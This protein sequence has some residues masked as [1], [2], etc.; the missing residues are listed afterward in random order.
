MALLGYQAWKADKVESGECTQTIRARRKN[1]VKVGETLYHYRGL[2]T[3]AAR[4]I[5]VSVC[6]ETFSLSLQVSKDG[7]TALWSAPEA[8][9]IAKVARRDGFADV[10]AMPEWF[11]TNHDIKSGGGIYWFDVI[12][13]TFPYAGLKK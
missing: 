10:K 12:R 5:L 11:L 13:W 4:K 3:K 6:K 7:K 1:P 2:R 9:D 8:D